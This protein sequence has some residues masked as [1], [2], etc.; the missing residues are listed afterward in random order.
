MGAV[1]DLFTRPGWLVAHAVVLTAAMVMVLLGLWQLRRLDD[2]REFNA[3]VGEHLARE[4]SELG[5]LLSLQ[6]DDA[7]YRGV[8]VRGRYLVDEETLVG[9]TSRDGAPG[10][11]V[12]T[13]VALPDGTAVL[14]ERGWVPYMAAPQVP[15]DGAD[16]PPGQVTVRGHVVPSR[17]AARHGPPGTGNVVFASAA[18][19]DLLASQLDVELQPLVVVLHDQEPA[20]DGLPLP[21]LLPQLD[22]GPHGSY[23]VQWF[24]FTAVLLMGYPLLLRRVLRDRAPP[25]AAAERLRVGSRD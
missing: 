10:Y 13:P 1:R 9:P 24:L 22:D 15:V 18:D 17:Q 5:Q 4:P 16:P 2:R 3:Q 12:I 19:V 21:S 8:V 11:A 20:Q 6:E 23:A 25:Q 14:V 7:A